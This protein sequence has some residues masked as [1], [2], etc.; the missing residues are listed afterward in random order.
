MTPMEKRAAE[1]AGRITIRRFDSAAEADRHDLEFW[2]QIPAPERV[3]QVWRLSQE[4]WRLRGEYHD[5]PGLC[6]SVARVHRG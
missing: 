5:E 1:R 4:L 6:R 2:K 3:L